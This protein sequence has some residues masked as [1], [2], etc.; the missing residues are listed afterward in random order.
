MATI[1]LKR[2]TRAQL[3]A[4]ALANNIIVGEPYLITDEGRLAVGVAVD[5]YAAMELEGA[6]GTVG[7]SGESAYPK[8]VASGAISKGKPVIL[9]SDGTVSMVV[10]GEPI[11]GAATIFNAAETTSKCSCYDIANEKVVIFY[12]DSGNSFFGTAVVCT[13]S[14]LSISFG[15]PVVFESA[16]TVYLTCCYDSLNGKIVVAYMD[17]GNSNY[18]TAIVGEVSGSSISFGQP[19]VFESAATTYLSCCYDSANNK[20]VIAYKGASSYLKAIV[21]SVVGS[22]ISFGTPTV[23]DTNSSANSTS[24]CYDIASG[25]TVIAYKGVN[26]Y[27]RAIVGTIDD[28]TISFGTSVVFESA[29]TTYISCIYDALNNKIVIAYQGASYYGKMIVGTVSGT[30][31]S[32]GNAVIFRAA[33]SNYICLCYDS[34]SGKVVVTFEDAGNA[35]SGIVNSGTVSGT[36]ILFD[37]QS[38]FHIPRSQNICCCYDNVNRKIVIAFQDIAN[39]NRGTAVVFERTGFTNNTDF[40]GIAQDSAANGS[41]VSVAVAYSTDMNQSG[42]T[43]KA[44]YYVDKTGLFTTTNAT[45]NTLAGKALSQN[46]LRITGGL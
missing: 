19:V 31:I 30:S 26:Y 17:A 37:V 46:V 23:F 1:K 14:D 16:N 6:A 34:S 2:G 28:T 40:I 33:Q 38:A 18:G 11:I 9:N 7:G 36:S 8:F 24:C 4:A 5:D 32:F 20:V 3:D 39:S 12:R 41:E 35:Y 15:T 13:I 27:G 22:E 43:P 10:G 44:T 42:L 45:G 21:G 25:K 29:T